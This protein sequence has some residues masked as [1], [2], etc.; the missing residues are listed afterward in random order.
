MIFMTQ[1]SVIQGSLV[2]VRHTGVLITGRPGTGKSMA[3]I[4]LALNGA[5]VVCDELVRIHKSD[6][7]TIVGEPVKS[8]ALIEVR[9]LGI[10]RLQDLFPTATAEHCAIDVVV[11]LDRYD[12]DLDVGRTEPE[13][14]HVDFFGTSVPRFRAPIAIGVRADTLVEMIVRIFKTNGMIRY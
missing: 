7:G 6:D 9:G 8:P 13:T 4:N 2:I 1:Y 14:D 11:E 5:V 3:A 10:F 12:A